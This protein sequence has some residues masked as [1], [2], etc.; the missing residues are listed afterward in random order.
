V[1]DRIRSSRSRRWLDEPEPWLAPTAVDYIKQRLKPDHHVVEWGAGASTLW[2]DQH[3][4]RVES[5]EHDPAWVEKVSHRL[6]PPSRVLEVDTEISEQAYAD[7]PEGL[8][9]ADWIVIDGIYRLECAARV[10]S[11]IDRALGRRPLWVVFDDTHR[12]DYAE[13]LHEL[14]VL[15]SESQHHCGRSLDLAVHMTSVLA[16][17]GQRPDFS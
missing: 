13:R 7:R 4:D 8:E 12:L 15:S 6:H 14:T 3:A 10:I 2:F 1:F 9:R 16:F 11:M 5:I 17:G